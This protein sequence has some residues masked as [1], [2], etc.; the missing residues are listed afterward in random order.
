MKIRSARKMPQANKI[1]SDREEP[2][3][4]FWRHYEEMKSQLAGPSDIKVIAYYGIGGVGKSSLLKKLMEEL[5]EQIKK[6]LFVHHDL[7]PVYEGRAVLE[8]IRNKLSEDYRFSFPLFDLSLYTYAKKLGENMEAPEIKSLADRS[9]ILST[10]FEYGEMLPGVGTLTQIL[11]AADKGISF[12]RNLL[13]KHRKEITEL[14]MLSQEELYAKLPYFF[15]L[16]LGENLKEAKEPLVFFLDTYEKMVNELSSIGEALNNDLWLRGEEGLIQNIPNVLWV[17]AGREKLKWTRFDAE[18]NEALDQHILG[19][20]SYADSAGYLT[21]AGIKDETLVREL[22]DLT[23]GTPVY[24]DLCVDRYLAISE[25][26]APTIE[27][28]G[29]DSYTLIERFVR[30]LDDAKKDIIYLFS[31]LGTW[32]KE[33]M[34]EIAGRVIPNFSISSYEKVKGFSFVSES[35][36]GI[37]TMHQTVAE[38]LFNSCPPMIKEKAVVEA[39]AYYL[40]KLKLCSIFSE[41][42][43]NY[44]RMAVKMSLLLYEDDEDYYAFYRQELEDIFASLYNA[45]FFHD[46]AGIFS[47]IYDRALR[48]ETSLLSGLA[49]YTVANILKMEGK[50]HQSL[51][52]NTKAVKIFTEHLGED[53]VLTLLA[54]KHQAS[55]L[56]DL[57]RYDEALSLNREVVKRQ[58]EVLGDRNPITIASTH[59]L[60]LTYFLT[61][62]EEEGLA[63]NKE[64][65]EIQQQELGESHPDTL[66]TLGNIASFLSRTGRHQEALDMEQRVLEKRKEVLGENHP[67]T[68]TALNNIAHTLALAEKYEEAIL[69]CD[70]VL[71]KRTS[72][73]GPLHPDTINALKNKIAY[74]SKLNRYDEA[75]TIG[76]EVLEKG[77]K[78]EQS[79]RLKIIEEIENLVTPAYESGKGERALEFAEI[80]LKKRREILGE[81]DALTIS[82]MCN[83]S[84]LLLALDKAEAYFKAMRELLPILEERLH[85][86]DPYFIESLNSAAWNLYQLG[87]AEEGLAYAEKIHERIADVDMDAVDKLLVMDTVALIYAEVGRPEEAETLALSILS[88]AESMPEEMDALLGDRYRTLGI[89]YDKAGQ[90]DKAELYFEKAS[91]CKAALPLR[92]DS[93]FQD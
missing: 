64:V 18:W 9:P 70:E 22:Y 40:K 10:L 16:D 92:E 47:P 30:Y 76:M 86:R 6:P 1:F 69:L 65:L 72:L 82:S 29:K 67:D 89:I 45:G 71:E 24:L 15:S 27:D 32:E 55:S 77:S 25:T 63:L 79:L 93:P 20:L 34:E 3:L 46:L 49:Q 17:I 39:L 13:S 59:N 5:Q 54:Q 42:L 88:E 23:H 36:P 8:K 12:V 74:L 41:A 87:R 44:L 61:G 19:S 43:P 50:Y 48:D 83:Y 28:F 62:Q 60:A 51:D 38:T 53:D 37:Y 52:L 21:A 4:T 85:P 78:A 14:D 81:E 31:C 66:L 73:L 84:S 57:E 33:L 7:G 75:L 2:R 26:K 91:H 90:H 35:A 58:R 68:I 56:F 11:S 80:A